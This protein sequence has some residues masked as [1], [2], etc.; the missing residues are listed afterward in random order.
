[1]TTART[2]RL[3]FDRWPI[4]PWP[5]ASLGERT[6]VGSVL[7][8]LLALPCMAAAV[9]VVLIAI[10]TQHAYRSYEAGAMLRARLIRR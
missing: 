5:R 2:I 10:L 7:I 6:A 4:D 3:P 1:M 8:L 9:A